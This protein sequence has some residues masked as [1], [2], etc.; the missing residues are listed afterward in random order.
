M[1]PVH[2]VYKVRCTYFSIFS[3]NLFVP[4]PQAHPAPQ[5]PMSLGYELPRV[6]TP[7]DPTRLAVLISG[8]GSGLEALLNYQHDHPRCHQTILVLADNPNAGG[9][10]HSSRHGVRS[11]SIP[12]P[13]EINKSE[14]RVA[15]EH[16]VHDE[17]VS[18]GVELVVL[19]GYMRI[20]TPWFVS[21]W[22]GRLV[23]IHPSLLPDFPGAHAHRDV[24][25]AGVGR[26][27]CTVHLVDEQVDSGLILAQSKIEVKPDDDESTLQ[28]RVK[29]AE[30]VLYPKT[31]DRLCSGLISL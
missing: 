12:L 19:S 23:N 16:L 24:L 18:S 5:R 9:L 25:A 22:K 26:T 29:K 20:L 13:M 2:R 4:N 10:E 17:L 14:R 15:H 8:G 31:L 28:E 1:L 27:G 11:V 21:R 30:H 7:E 3:A 6:A